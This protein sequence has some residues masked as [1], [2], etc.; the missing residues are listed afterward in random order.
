MLGLCVMNLHNI[1]HHIEVRACVFVCVFRRDWGGGVGGGGLH[2]N[3][4][5]LL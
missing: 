5:S 1:A 3:S 4:P 2:K